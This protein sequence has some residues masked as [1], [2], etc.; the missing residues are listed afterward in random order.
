MS[1]P[2]PLL[3]LQAVDA[4]Y[5]GR[6]VLSGVNFT[7]EAGEFAGLIGANGAGKTTLFR[8]VLGLIKP[9]SGEVT[10]AGKPPKTVRSGIGYVPQ[11]H[12]FAWDFP[13]TI[14]ETVM[15]GRSHLMGMWRRAGKEDWK[16]VF[17]ALERVGL[18]DLRN[19][20]IAELSGG[21]RQR[22]LLARALSTAPSLLLLDE[23]FTGVDAPTQTMLTELYR[24]LVAEGMTILMSTHDMYSAATSCSRIIGL[25][26]GVDLDAPAGR[27]SVEAL[28]RWL[29]GADLAAPANL[30]SCEVPA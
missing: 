21:Q 19:R 12:L 29:L 18:T 6:S 1:Q 9:L 27:F 20:P 15:T 17:T 14:A 10:I 13:I 26:G 23:P 25:R 4:G 8:T 16:Q 3:K 24:S 7:L 5:P 22:V 2:S 11:K 30:A 28:H